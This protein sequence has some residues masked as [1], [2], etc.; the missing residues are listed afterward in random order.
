MEVS[1]GKQGEDLVEKCQNF[2]SSMESPVAS[3]ESVKKAM[4]SSKSSGVEPVAKRSGATSSLRKS[5]DSLKTTDSRSTRPGSTL[6]EPTVSSI[7]AQRRN[8]ASSAL[9]KK[10]AIASKQFDNGSSTDERKVSHSN[11]DLSRKS[12]A[13]TRRAS[14]PSV[15][16]KTKVSDTHPESKK[17]SPVPRLLQMSESGKLDSVKK[18]SVRPSLSGTTSK[19]APSSPLDN[20]TGRSS[21]LKR[22]T[23]NISSPST[24]S[25]RTISSLKS[26]SMSSS[27]DRGSSLSGRRKSSTPDG[28]DSRF[29]MLPQVDI[30][31]SDELRLDRR[32]HKVRTLTSLNL[33]SNLEFV[34]LRDNLLSSIEGIET[35]KW[36]KVLD[37]SFND[38]KGPGFEPLENCKALQQLYLAGNQITSLASLPQLPNLEFL[39]IAQNK[40][41]SL[42]MASQPRLQV[43]AASKNK[44]STLK[45]FPHLPVLEHLRVEENAILEM[46]HLEA[47]SILLVGPTLKKFND[48]DLSPKEV[49]IAKLYP[50][51]TA[52]CIRNGWEFT[53]PELAADSTF[54]F[55]AEQ[56]KDQFPPGYMLQEA[57]IDQPFEE[58]ACR[59]HFSFVNSNGDSDLELKYQW[60]IGDRT[61]TNFVAITDA[62]G[63][64]YWPK[65]G[66]I[67][68]CLKVECT[69]ILGE[70]EYPSIFALSSPISPGTGYPKVLSLSVQG[71]LVEG[72][73][74]KGVAEVAWC[75]GTPG[76]GVASWLR[77]RWN[78][79][80]VAVVGA[81][82]EEYTLTAD[83]IDSSLVF[84]YTP[85]TE[86]G[87]RGEPQYAM[88]D[89]IKAATPSVS[90]VQILG[91]AVE[92]N[93]IKGIGKYFGGREGPSKFEWLRE[94]K[95]TGDFL[96]ASSG[97]ME[98]TLT[99]EDV[100]RRMAFVYIPINLEGQEG[101]SVSV[102]TDVV[103][104]APPKVTKLKIVGD[105]REGNKVTVTGTVTGGTEGS[106]RVQWFKT[107]L[108]VLDGENGLEAVSTSKIAK[109]F[110][111]PLG[112]VGYYIVAKFTPMAADGESGEPAYVISENVVETLPP[113]L[114]FLSV[115]GDYFEGQML[116]ASYGYIGGHEGRS[117][118][119]W[120]L[121][122]NET[123][124]GTLIQ[125]ASGHLQYRIVKDAI[126]KFISFKCT[127]IRDDGFVGESRTIFG[128]ERVRAGSPRL[129]SLQI[130]G[131]GIEGTTLIADKKYWG[132]EE[133]DSVFRW[134]LTSSDGAQSEIVGATDASYSLSF[135]DIGFLVSVSCEPVRSDLARGPIILSEHIGP[136][137]PGPPTCQSLKLVGSMVEGDRLTFLAQYTGGERGI[138]TYEWF[139][140]KENGAKEKLTSDEFLD[141]NLDDVGRCIELIYTPVR[142]DGLKGS[143]KSIVSDAIAPANP[144]G[145][146]LVLPQCFEDKE[147]IPFK[148][149][150]GGIEG[151][152]ECIWY[153]T[154]RKLKGL[155]LSDVSAASE[156]VITVG[157]SVTYTPSIEDV[158]FH[159]VLYWVP[160]RSDGNHGDPLVAISDSPVVAA[161][162]VVSNV[163]V[164][165]LGSGIYAGQGKYYGGHEGSSLYSWYRETNDGTI[166]L[167]TGANSTS[168]EVTDSD[169]NCRLLFGYTP[170]R[171]DTVVGELRLSEPSHIIL[172]E[173]PVVD[174]LSFNGKQMEGET[175]T[176]VEVIPKRT[177]QHVWEKY[178]KEIKY[179][180]FCSVGHEDDQSFE[181]LNLQQSCSYKLRFEDIGRCLKCECIVTDV[182]GRLT[183]PVSAIT[184]HIL[185][186]KPKIDKLEIEGRGFHTNLYAV[187]GVYT[188][189]KEGKSRIQW[190][191]SMIG[192]PDLISIP[193]EI[194]R[195][196]EANVDDVGY[197]LVVVYTPIREDGVEG[198]PVSASTDLIA[199]EPDV[200]KEVKQKLDLG[201][202]KFETLCDKDRQPKQVSGVGNLERRILE[203][204]RKRIKVMKPG[205]KATFPTTEIRGTYAPP[206]HVELYRN[207]QH[208]LKIV[209][210]S[211][212]EVDLMV[213]TRHMRDV[214][215]LVIRGFA[216][217]FNSTSLNSLLKIEA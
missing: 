133:G 46:S 106:S 28:R 159:L 144:R 11:S 8:S 184:A 10:P 211:E 112:A 29:M 97:S 206:F 125:E 177:Q 101:E 142:K 69:P 103:K 120:Y 61:A 170:V 210:D 152:G 148:F 34:Y 14:L 180:W 175:L 214:I 42:S 47:A 203:V 107:S 90:N 13:E 54:C 63:E 100:G 145:L 79:S 168:Y 208:R 207:D 3:A 110:R 199:V 185:P 116:T 188:G 76:K 33:S 117:L 24:R 92:G 190:L 48:R 155:E 105:L 39:S 25:P 70:M 104:K 137:L 27:M 94:R 102:T 53:Q 163:C 136:V 38:F 111:V 30:K 131:K 124:E 166:T 81:E 115:T 67:E 6:T 134:F 187:R 62:L 93:T 64:V 113:S 209:V 4:R 50:P 59:C 151:S 21:R 217:R 109:A 49:E 88:T 172:P 164:K 215:V 176:A 167:I 18:P 162:P 200:Y 141:L 161:L 83:D 12:I 186:G 84:M 149:Y 9:E 154:L 96:L 198:Q 75:G 35:L 32:G 16:S 31:A 5:T 45:G 146:E 44:I 85:V 72:N 91:D 205:Y 158:G 57:S 80:P 147:V 212:N 118:Y 181:P 182:F 1:S 128:Q 157:N 78:S 15:S 66:D 153:R 40:L 19:K 56:W 65:H 89:F 108:P 74:I 77:R 99:K 20:S 87:A 26:G 22:V 43:L 191:R 213:Q 129:L 73:V 37:L 193:G 71:E 165:D 7:N 216:Q 132:G 121:H 55:L 150:F 58:D 197:R 171:S 41:K 82:D 178:K 196:Y 122:E 138:C 123:E 201:S 179:Q 204:N 189:G 174:M 140:V 2:V 202:V 60:F 173:L 98:Y 195:M 194:G 23:S 68:K 119:N 192:S 52:M 114:N 126:G 127:P 139:R 135:D 17:S 183:E 156:D 86:E 36:V 130:I 169:Y 51:H 143:P 160:V 95:E